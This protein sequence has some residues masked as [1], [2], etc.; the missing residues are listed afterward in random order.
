MSND[1]ELKRLEQ[2]SEAWE[3]TTLKS[4]L[5]KTGELKEEFKTNSG[6]P[7]K[8]LYT[9]LDAEKRGWNY[10]DRLGFPGEYPYVRGITPTMYRGDLPRSFMYSGYGS[11]EASNARY[12]YL[13]KQGAREVIIAPDLPTQMGYDSDNPLSRGEVGRIGVAIDS[14]ADVEVILDGIPLDSVLVGTQANANTLVMLA[15]ILAATEKQGVI[16]GKVKSSVQNDVLKE[17]V[18]RGTYIFPPR[19]GL[20]LSCDVVEYVIRNKLTGI[21][22]MLYVGYH[23]REAG[24]NAVQEMAF[25]LANAVA[26]IEELLNRGISVDELHPP[27]ALFVAGLDLFEEVAKYRAFRRMWARFMKERFNAKNPRVMALSYTTGSQASLYT[28]QQPMNNVVRGTIQALAEVLAGVQTTNIAAMD[29]ALS[30]PTTESATLVLRTMQIVDYETGVTNTVDPLG[31][32]YY[33]EALTDELEEKATRLFKKVESLGGAVAG[34]EQG[35]QEK[36]IAMEAYAQLRRVESGDRVV[37]GVNQF[38]TDEPLTIQ[39]MKVDP[40]EEERQIGKVRRLRKERDNE[41]VQISLRELKQAAEEGVN[42]T[43]YFLAAVK[44]YATVGEI[45]DTLR[46]VYGEYRRPTY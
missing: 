12:K 23:F 45:F 46:S 15:F 3:T 28:A 9:S 6:I 5:E 22:P 38:K 27:T 32:S 39:L 44:I 18:A 40:E 43:P 20:K 36:Q 17:Y 11:A 34:I 21:S 16:A 29:E 26:Y 14:L 13:L 2:A 33:V 31:G 42:L 7:V 25:T 35:Y 41:K 1:E 37:V 24:A 4:E 19:V 10:T 30:I 8:R